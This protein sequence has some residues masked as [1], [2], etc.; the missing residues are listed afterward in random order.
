MQD[1]N[2]KQLQV[3]DCVYVIPTQLLTIEA[4]AWHKVDMPLLPA[5]VKKVAV[6]KHNRTIETTDSNFYLEGEYFHSL[7]EAKTKMQEEIDDLFIDLEQ[8]AAK[9]RQLRNNL[10]STKES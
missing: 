5:M 2:T 3:G 6:I 10:S 4:L 9:L 7:E 8:R 1:T